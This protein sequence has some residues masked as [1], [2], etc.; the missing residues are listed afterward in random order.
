MLCINGQSQPVL[1]PTLCCASMVSL[2]QFCHLPYVVHQWSVSASLVTYLMWCINGQS[3]PVLSPTLCGAP[4]LLHQMGAD[5]PRDIVNKLTRLASYRYVTYPVPETVSFAKF[6]ESGFYYP[7]SGSDVICA[8]CGNRVD[9]SH[10]SESPDDVTFHGRVC[11][12]A[13]PRPSYDP[14]HHDGV[15]TATITSPINHTV[16]SINPVRDHVPSIT[17]TQKPSRSSSDSRTNGISRALTE[18]RETSQ[19]TQYDITRSLLQKENQS[20]GV[21]KQVDLY[22]LSSI[23]YQIL[24]KD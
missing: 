10:F 24:E 1:S 4:M 20:S 15:V 14:V 11:T 12:F 13:Q 8:G 18:N 9:L 7:G 6:S 2:S 21:D 16:D 22:M 19:M 5:N 17:D 3:Q 23:D